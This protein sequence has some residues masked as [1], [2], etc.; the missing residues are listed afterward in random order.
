MKHAEF[1]AAIVLLGLAGCAS[2]PAR[3]P[4]QAFEASSNVEPGAREL[5]ILD[6][7]AG[8]DVAPAKVEVQA[9]IAEEPDNRQAKVLLAEIDQDPK[10]L[11]GTLNFDVTIKA[12][13]TFAELAERYM[14]DRGLAYALARYN[15]FN[16]PDQAAPGQVVQIP[17][18][19]SAVRADA[20]PASRRHKPA[21]PRAKAAE[22]PD[23]PAKP[24]AAKPT[25]AK[26]VEPPSPA[27]PAEK[28]SPRAT[29]PKP[30]ANPL[31]S[32][33]TPQPKP[34]AAAERGA[35]P[36]PAPGPAEA[37]KPA[38]PKPSPPQHDP[39]KAASLRSDALVLMNKG[40]IGQAVV[41]LRQAAALDPDSG[42]IKA[43]L[44]RAVRIQHGPPAP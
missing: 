2:Q 30:A 12:G 40:D 29:E 26:P 18:S 14:H 25:A 44:D 13:D 19:P 35:P 1:A 16:P 22:T 38:P 23:A 9:L 7:L 10:V 36:K 5:K 33:K 27:H 32:A 4:G 3:L 21:E 28:P 6:H 41:V 37:A 11:L 34:A 17:G 20:W 8:G 43:D 15:G 31:E 42:P 39:A 24:T